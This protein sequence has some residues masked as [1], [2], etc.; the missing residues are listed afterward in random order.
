MS[1]LH[2]LAS[3]ILLPTSL[4]TDMDGKALKP[5]SSPQEVASPIPLSVSSAFKPLVTVSAAGQLESAPVSHDMVR[6]SFIETQ[7]AFAHIQ[8]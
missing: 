4:H 1:V 8:H 6:F 7:L 3:L 2:I 5:R